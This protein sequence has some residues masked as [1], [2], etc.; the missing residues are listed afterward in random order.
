LSVDER[1]GGGDGE[2]LPALFD[3][4]NHGFEQAA[5]EVKT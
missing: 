4:E 2:D 3:F 5:F 1:S